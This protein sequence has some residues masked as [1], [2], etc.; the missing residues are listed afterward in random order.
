M[1]LFHFGLLGYPV[2]HSFSPR[3]H[4]AA[5]DGLNLQGSYELFPINPITDG[6]GEM[7][8]LLT[9]MRRGKLHGL[10]VTIPYKMTVIPY[11][12]ELL[13]TAYAAGAVNTILRWGNKLVGENF[14]CPA[15]MADLSVCLNLA[16][17]GSMSGFANRSAVVLGAGGSA[18]AVVY[19]LLKAGWHPRVAARRLEQAEE[20][21]GTFR[22][23]PNLA[24][25]R[26]DDLFELNLEGLNL[27]VNSTPL[28][29]YPD[30]S[31]MAWPAGIRLP[32]GALVYDLVYNLSL[33]H[34]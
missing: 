8:A 22:E 19:G 16:G 5:L 11:L 7:E 1:S 9:S 17:M 6:G 20:L 33:I 13:P 21:A 23:F 29:M 28:G 14:D 18:R 25:C 27:I 24:T 31:G 10:N 32:A 2:Q 15:F 4:Q 3:L 30:S 26:L 12:D 34:I